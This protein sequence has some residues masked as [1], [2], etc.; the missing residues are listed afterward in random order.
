MANEIRKCLPADSLEDPGDSV[1]D[2]IDCG[3]LKQEEIS[4]AGQDRGT[5]NSASRR[6]QR[7]SANG[8]RL[9]LPWKFHA[10][11]SGS[12]RSGQR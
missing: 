9:R 11:V 6:S 3:N 7:T 4:E 1:L 12:G 10:N 2:D 5:W 8:S